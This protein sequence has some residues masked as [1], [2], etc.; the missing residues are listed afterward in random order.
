MSFS[1]TDSDDDIDF[2][3][4]NWGSF[5]RQKDAYDR[6]LT[7]KQFTDIVLKPNSKFKER[8]KKR[9]R[10]YLNVIYPKKQKV[11]GE[12]NQQT[13]QVS[14]VKLSDTAINFLENT[15]KPI[16]NNTTKINDN[17]ETGIGRT[18]L[19]GIAKG[20]GEVVNNEKYPE[21]FQALLDFG[22][23][24][25]PSYLP[26]NAIQLNHNYKTKKH[27]DGNNIG[28]SLAVAFGDFTG[29]ELVIEGVGSFQTKDYPVIFNGS[30][31]EHYNK[32]ISGD[33][34]SLVYFV[35]APANS[36]KDEIQDIHKKLLAKYP[37]SYHKTIGSGVLENETV[38]LFDKN[39]PKE[40]P[41]VKAYENPSGGGQKEIAIDSLNKSYDRRKISL[42]A[43]G[44]F[45]LLLPEYMVQTLDNRNTYT[46]RLAS[47]IS[48]DRNIATRQGVQSVIIRTAPIAEP[49]LIRQ[50]D[51]EDNTVFEMNDFDKADRT[52]LDDYYEDMEAY[53]GDDY[54]ELAYSGNPPSEKKVVARGRPETLPKNIAI[55]ARMKSG[56]EIKMFS[57]TINK[58]GNEWV[59][60]LK[61]YSSENGMKY[62]DCMKS[63]ECKAQYKKKS[64]SGIIDSMGQAQARIALKQNTLGLGA[65]AGSAPSK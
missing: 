65:N 4:L 54:E 9:A 46:A 2:E 34:Y 63:A 3:D 27:I 6:K 62:K 59:E 32:P 38:K 41:K 15:L 51:A 18:Q 16:I 37:P 44:D 39:Q 1:D 56:G 50:I 33:R 7:L 24:I 11:G 43:F 5:T 60:H 20:L 29:G 21:L 30:L 35:N 57:N 25:V 28:L 53:M 26:F 61:R 23:K 17:K 49:R 58:M 47:T 52:L 14:R 10:F 42:P 36:T 64:G 55:N 19:F 31:R 13:K 22:R 45:I 12:I 48:K 8:T 40:I